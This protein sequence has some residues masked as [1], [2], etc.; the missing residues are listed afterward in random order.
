MSDFII[1]VFEYKA[2]FS[3]VS[4]YVIL[5]RYKKPTYIILKF[6]SMLY[7]SKFTG[8]FLMIFSKIS[9]IIRNHI[10][11]YYENSFFLSLMISLIYVVSK[12]SRLS[13]RL[14][15]Y[16]LDVER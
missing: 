3:S 6:V 15:W 1:L 2:F 5:L 14:I 4:V 16:D 7:L 11:F 9:F 8:L 10:A 13:W 12:A